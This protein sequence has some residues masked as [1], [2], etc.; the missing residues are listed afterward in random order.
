MVYE[1]S[2]G[3]SRGRRHGMLLPTDISIHTSIHFYESLFSDSELLPWFDL[4]SIF[5]TDPKEMRYG[6]SAP[7][8]FDVLWMVSLTYTSTTSSICLYIREQ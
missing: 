7:T 1:E 2:V 8:L 4:V 6:S 3:S 5:Q